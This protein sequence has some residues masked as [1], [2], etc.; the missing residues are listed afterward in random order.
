MSEEIKPWLLLSSKLVFE[1]KFLNIIEDTVLLPSGNEA[2]W[3]CFDHQADGA[4]TIL[5]NGDG[6]IL[7][8]KQYC[9]PPRSVV[10]EFPGGGIG[11]NES[12]EEAA[13]RE[14]LEEV[15]IWPH[16]LK[17]IGSFLLNNR[18][19]ASRLHVFVGTQLEVRGDSPEAQEFVT[20]A[21]FTTGEIEEMIENGKID[22]STLLAT[23][24]IYRS[25]KD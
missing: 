4:C 10:Y 2:N 14:S 7:L 8:A 12:P 24:A 6:K 11:K 3:L 18:R 20:S 16:A 9:H 19:S 25:L 21:W 15:G 22:N 23:W 17:R 5:I 1:R 13:Q